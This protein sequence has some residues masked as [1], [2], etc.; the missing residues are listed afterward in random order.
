MATPLEF[1]HTLSHRVQGLFTLTKPLQGKGWNNKTIAIMC[2]CMCEMYMCAA[3]VY[4]GRD[5]VRRLTVEVEEPILKDA[6]HS[7]QYM[8]FSVFSAHA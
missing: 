4:M 2:A 1:H 8:K 5:F 6:Y 3:C 7:T